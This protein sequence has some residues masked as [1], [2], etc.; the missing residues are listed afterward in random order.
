MDPVTAAIPSL[1]NTG[2]GLWQ[3]YQ[4]KKGLDNLKRPE[5]NRPKNVDANLV[6][7]T[8]EFG[9]ESTQEVQA[10]I[11]ANLA[12]AN[13]VE[14]ATTAGVGA[15]S[16]A[17]IEAA[18]SREMRDIDSQS[19]QQRAQNLQRLMGANQVQADYVDQEFQIN[20]FQPYVEKYNEYREM[21]GAGIQNTSSGL[22][23]LSSVALAQA[24]M[25]LG[26]A[27]TAV[28]QAPAIS[29][30][31]NGLGAVG[32]QVNALGAQGVGQSALNYGVGTS[33]SINDQI[34]RALLLVR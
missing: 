34:A 9:A 28:E 8:Q 31:S 25:N 16:A 33:S 11:D 13:R 29:Q 23:G 24:Y 18:R 22:S 1:F 7:A 10:R 30:V 15:G 2:V 32:N 6:L 19:Y 5:Y 12:A 14:A 20:K 21:L 3:M 17:A 27:P 26:K 4:G